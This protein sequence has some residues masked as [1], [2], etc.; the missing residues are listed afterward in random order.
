MNSFVFTTGR[1]V[2]CHV[3]LRLLTLFLTGFPSIL[4]FK[5]SRQLPKLAIFEQS[6]VFMAGKNI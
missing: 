5:K 2:A 3:L 6:V 1:Q 4:K